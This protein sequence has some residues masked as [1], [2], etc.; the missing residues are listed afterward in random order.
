MNLAE[1]ARAIKNG[2]NQAIKT[3]LQEI[4]NYFKEYL[5]GNK[6]E[7]LMESKISDPINQQ[8]SYGVIILKFNNEYVGGH[9]KK[10]RRIIP[11]ITLED[12]KWICPDNFFKTHG[13]SFHEIETDV[14]WHLQAITRDKLQEMGFT[15]AVQ[16]GPTIEGPGIH[17]CYG[18]KFLW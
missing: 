9:E 17:E 13:I 10:E 11:I 15:T 6:F 3:V 5:N 8:N 14:G 12:R 16:Y 18:V 4:A 1:K 7:Q 2:R